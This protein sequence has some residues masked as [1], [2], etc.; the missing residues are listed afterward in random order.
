MKRFI[1]FFLTIL[2]FCSFGFFSCNFEKA[3]Y[4]NAELTQTFEVEEYGIKISAPNNFEETTRPLICSLQTKINH[5]T[6]E[7]SD[8]QKPI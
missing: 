6:L 5:Y 7:F 3:V 8:F 1:S 4:D 2:L